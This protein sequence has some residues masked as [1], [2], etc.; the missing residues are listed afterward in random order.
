MEKQAPQSL[1]PGGLEGTRRD[2]FVIQ[3]G[4]RELPHWVVARQEGVP[5]RLESQWQDF[6][7]TI[8][9]P[10]VG[11]G[12]PQLPELASWDDLLHFERVFGAC[13]WPRGE[14]VA[15]LMPA[16]KSAIGCRR[17]RP[18][19]REVRKQDNRSTNCLGTEIANETGRSLEHP[20][21][22][23]EEVTAA[24]E[25]TQRK[26]KSHLCIECGRKKL[27]RPIRPGKTP[28]CSTSGEKEPLPVCRS[29]GGKSFQSQL[30]HL[31]RY[32]KGKSIL[33]KTSHLCSECGDTFSQR[34]YLVSH[35]RS[36]YLE[37]SRTAVVS[38]SVRNSQLISPSS[39]ILRKWKPMAGLETR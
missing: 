27:H 19:G 4:I 22:K 21:M 24:P 28:E 30:S 36:H 9:S 14:R 39:R 18:A 16:F 10:S 35:Q 1:A 7:R 6:L 8:Q 12:S 25:G 20:E 34:A 5:H 3:T 37:S 11:W 17:Q 23:E 13:H 32:Q 26:E 31:T 33:G 2:N 38:A 29:L 15:R